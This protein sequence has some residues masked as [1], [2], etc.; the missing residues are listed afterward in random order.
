MRVSVAASAEIEVMPK[1]ETFYVWVEI[2]PYFGERVIFFS[3]LPLASNSRNVIGGLGPAV[4]AYVAKRGTRAK[5]LAMTA[6]FE[7]EEI[8]GSGG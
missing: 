4:R 8:D 5:L 1:V 6:R 3:G 2:D 7:L